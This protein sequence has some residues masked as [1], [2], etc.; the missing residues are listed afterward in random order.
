MKTYIEVAEECGSFARPKDWYWCLC[1]QGD[2]IVAMFEESET[3][4]WK[5]NG[6]LVVTIP[7]CERKHFKR[8]VW[9][10]RMFNYTGCRV[11]DRKK[12]TTD[13]IS[14]TFEFQKKQYRTRRALV[15]HPSRHVT[16]LDPCGQRRINRQSAKRINL[17]A[18]RII[19]AA[20]GAA[21]LHR[22]ITHPWQTRALFWDPAFLASCIQNEEVGKLSEVIDAGLWRQE[23]LPDEIPQIMKRCRSEL[24][25]LAGAFE[26]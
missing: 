21:Q 12:N 18:Y 22:A 19:F 4:R 17:N 24:Y 14:F 23:L 16:V 25:E 1:R 11:V 2:D 26:L 8:S 7:D 6:D 9:S 3:A 5:P 15:I 10:R 13:G 20:M